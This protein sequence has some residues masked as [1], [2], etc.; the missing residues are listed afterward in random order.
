[1]LS[2]HGKQYKNKIEAMSN[3]KI[4]E[5]N[6]DLIDLSTNT[7]DI[8]NKVKTLIDVPVNKMAL[9]NQRNTMSKNDND[10]YKGNVFK[11]SSKQQ[12][13]TRH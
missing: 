1:M 2:N 6:N 7:F 4:E 13:K 8:I 3:R 11:T 9:Y 10:I 12:D 5:L